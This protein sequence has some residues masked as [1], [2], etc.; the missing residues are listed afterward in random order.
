MG[1]PCAAAGL[2]AVAC[3]L[4]ARDVA[5]SRGDVVEELYLRERA[6]GVS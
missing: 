2:R 4:R 1:T 5:H 6:L 3:A